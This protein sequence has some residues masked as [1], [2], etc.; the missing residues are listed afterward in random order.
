MLRLMTVKSGTRR[1]RRYS[2]MTP[3]ITGSSVQIEFLTDPIYMSYEDKTPSINP[4]TA[5]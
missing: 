1:F 5:K 4:L 3:N 2:D